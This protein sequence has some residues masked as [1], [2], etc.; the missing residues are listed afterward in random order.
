MPDGEFAAPP[1]LPSGNVLAGTLT[2]TSH[3]VQLT[4]APLT[5]Q[6][7]VSVFSFVAD[8]IR[9]SGPP[10]SDSAY[11]SIRHVSVSAANHSGTK[12]P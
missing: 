8:P 5:V 6:G 9:I 2:S 4:A 10:P 11:T 7:T 3:F 12:A 1:G